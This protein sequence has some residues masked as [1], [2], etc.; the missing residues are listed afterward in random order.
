MS[1]FAIY[2]KCTYLPSSECYK[3][4]PMIGQLGFRYCLGAERHQDITWVNVYPNWGHREFI[5][6]HLQAYPWIHPL[7]ILP[8]YFSIILIHRSTSPPILPPTHPLPFHTPV[9]PIIDD[10]C[11]K[12]LKYVLEFNQFQN[13][14]YLDAPY[15]SNH[16]HNA[17][18]VLASCV[19]R[20]SSAMI[21]ITAPLEVV[22][23]RPS[24]HVYQQ[25]I[26]CLSPLFGHPADMCQQLAG[27]PHLLST[28][29]WPSQ[30]C[31]TTEW[32][33][34][35]VHQIND[36][37]NCQGFFLCIKNVWERVGFQ[38][39]V[40]GHCYPADTLHQNDVILT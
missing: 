36:W 28:D 31:D 40:S 37:T 5:S 4:L 6:V 13:T 38:I 33:H 8:D 15:S 34:R 14:L 19:A 26:V 32:E 25:A 21:L 30:A 23:Y 20:S 35:L 17:T 16:K 39:H 3:I 2:T 24:T 9:Y 1:N 22:V 11:L 12:Y 7:K 10:N 18:D 29:D 27:P